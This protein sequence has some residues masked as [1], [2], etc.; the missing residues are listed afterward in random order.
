MINEVDKKLNENIENSQTLQN[1][2]NKENINDKINE[3][4]DLFTK[5]E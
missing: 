4:F 1:N 2:A 5:L 3:L